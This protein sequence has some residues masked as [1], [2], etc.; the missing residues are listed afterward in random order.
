MDTNHIKITNYV[1]ILLPQKL[2]G[3]LPGPQVLLSF[4]IVQERVTLDPWQS[5]ESAILEHAF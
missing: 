4:S 5:Q 2:G 1:Y 3:H